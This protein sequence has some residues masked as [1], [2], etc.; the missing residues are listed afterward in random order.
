MERHALPSRRR[1]FTGYGPL[2]LLPLQT[3]ARVTGLVADGLVRRRLL[4]L[5]FVPGTVVRAIRRSPLGDPTAY[6]VRGT[7]IA[8]RAEDAARVLIGPDT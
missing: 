4:D 2:D 3:S 6:G 5:G 8:L 1:G 7:V